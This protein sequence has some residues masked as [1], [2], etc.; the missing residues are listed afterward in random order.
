MWW[1]TYRIEIYVLFGMVK[2]AAF[3]YRRIQLSCFPKA[4]NQ[5]WRHNFLSFIRFFFWSLWWYENM[6][7]SEMPHSKFHFW[8]CD[9]SYQIYENKSTF[10]TSAR[11]HV[12]VTLSKHHKLNITIIYCII[13]IVYF[14]LSSFFTARGNNFFR[15]IPLEIEAT[16]FF[17]ADCF[18]S[19]NFAYIRYISYFVS[20]L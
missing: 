8:N 12:Y 1:I 3:N 14:I 13:L 7:C 20:Y 19:N 4:H 2:Q 9:A 17:F 5:N 15:S 6:F 16:I 18:K 11:E 10:I